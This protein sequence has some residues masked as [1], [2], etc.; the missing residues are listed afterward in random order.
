VSDSYD[1]IVVGSGFGGGVSAC[2]L[3][4]AG[5]S[6]CV[7]ERGRRFAGE[8]FISEPLQA[9][10]L[11]WHP[12]LNPG[13]IFDLRLFKDLSVLTAAGVG[14]GSLVYANVQLRA[15]PQVFEAG[16]PAGIDRS[17]LDPYYERVEWVLEPRPTPEQPPLNKMRAFR[18]MAAAAGQ[19]ATALPLAVHF[20][21]D[22]VNPFGQTPQQGCTNL[23]RCNI[24]CPR[25]AKNTVDLTYLARAER[26]G[27]HVRPHCEAIRLQAP[28]SPGGRW[29]VSYRGLKDTG[30]GQVDAPVVVLSA[31]S[32]GSTR[33]LLR[34]RRRLPRLSPALGS[35]FSGNGDALGAA[36]NPSRPDVRDAHTELGPVMTSRIDY[37]E[38]HRFMLADGGL[39]PG[40][41]G[42]L[43]I[44]RDEAAL[45]GWRKHLLLRLEHLAVRLGVSD[46]LVTPRTVKLDLDEEPIEDSLVF[47]MLGQDAADG[48]M[49]LTPLFRCLDIEWSQAKSKRLFAA[50]ERTT[51]ELG[52][53][54]D[55]EPFFA[56]GNGPL[57]K[58]ITVHP[59]GGCPMADD[60][61]GGVV[62]GY[63]RVHS[64]PG[65]HVAD[66]SIIPTALG[67]NP[68][69]TIAALAERNVERLIADGG[70]ALKPRGDAL[71]PRREPETP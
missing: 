2:R 71:K 54:V 47:L 35:R 1:A 37:W 6:V 5:W 7:L 22:R 11:L 10:R 4:E 66:G 49:R 13:G 20:G 29:R 9:P 63:G 18:G 55:A 26:E 21:E 8:D 52:T 15:H 28:A 43:K 42:L 17:S 25:Q 38:Q 62:D 12:T 70:A 32:L 16:W 40:F 3:A 68:S 67:V 33:L 14:G 31:G 23:G 58:D 60:P 24:G 50:M 56:L 57:G 59:L 45:V 53:A 36:F 64:Y 46:R 19:H 39:P 51:H 61:A 48:R 34:N 65:L 30:D 41:T 44:L 69:E 27:A